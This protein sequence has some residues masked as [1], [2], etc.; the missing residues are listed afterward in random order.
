MPAEALVRLTQG[1]AAELR[2][3]ARSNNNSDRPQEKNSGTVSGPIE[4]NHGSSSG[5]DAAAGGNGAATDS[6]GAAVAKPALRFESQQFSLLR[7]ESDRFNDGDGSRRPKPQAVE[8]PEP[9]LT[10]TAVQAKTGSATPSLED[11]QQQE[12]K[13]EKGYAAAAVPG[14]D[15]PLPE[16]GAVL[17]ADGFLVPGKADGGVYL[18]VPTAAE[19]KGFVAGVGSGADGAGVDG[20]GGGGVGGVEGKGTG[21]AAGAG[22]AERIVRL[23]GAKRLA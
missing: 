15:G 23:T 19:E 9:R 16:H 6:V 1:R 22:T 4:G 21:T 18:V 14:W 17:I 12:E 11:P 13:E 2:Y 5:S 8:S 7:L 3:L 10:T 20:S